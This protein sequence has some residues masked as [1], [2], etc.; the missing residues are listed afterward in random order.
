MLRRRYGNTRAD[1]VEKMAKVADQ[2]PWFG[3]EQECVSAR[4]R[5]GALLL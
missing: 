5:G 2:E 4:A 3:I 1:C